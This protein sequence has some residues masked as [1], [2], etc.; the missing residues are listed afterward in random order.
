MSN[1]IDIS[2]GPIEFTTHTKAIQTRLTWKILTQ[3][4]N[5]INLDLFY[6]QIFTK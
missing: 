6:Q 3:D 5:A 1:S 4:F 2:P